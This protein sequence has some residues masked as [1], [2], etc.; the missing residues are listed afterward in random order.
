MGKHENKK[1]ESVHVV[2]PDSGDSNDKHDRGQ[3]MTM[4]RRIRASTVEVEEL[5]EVSSKAEKPN[6]R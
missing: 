3:T 4:R 1:V 5:I 2:G 6:A